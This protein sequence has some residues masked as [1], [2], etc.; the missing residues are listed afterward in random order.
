MFMTLVTNENKVDASKMERAFIGKAWV[1][2]VAKGE[3]KGIEF[4]AIRLNRGTKI[5]EITDECQFTLWPN[6]KREGKKDADYSLSIQYP[7]A[8]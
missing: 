8:A 4:L 7:K 1:N 6:E 2:T 3:Y 5:S